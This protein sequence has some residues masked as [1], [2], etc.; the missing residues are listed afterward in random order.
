MKASVFQGIRATK[1]RGPMKKFPYLSVGELSLGLP[2]VIVSELK[3]LVK[4]RDLRSL[5]SK[6]FKPD[7]DGCELLPFMSKLLIAGASR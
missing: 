2:T 4:L 7:A 3:F 1:D 5:G 6:R